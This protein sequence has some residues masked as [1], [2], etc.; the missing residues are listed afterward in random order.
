MRYFWAIFLLVSITLVSILGFRG[1][2][3]TQPPFYI[4]PDMDFQAKYLPQGKNPFFKD[5]RN[6]R[7]S[8][9]G[10]IARG[11]A[12]T[13]ELVFSND[14]SYLPAQNSELY[15]GKTP[16][17]EWFQGFPVPITYTLIQQG[18][19]K[20]EIFCKV[21]HGST[22]DGNGITKQY[23]ISATPSYHDDRIRS[24]HEG[25]IFNT[26]THGKNTMFPYG[27]KLSPQE[28]WAVVAYVRCLQ[29]AQMGT[30]DDV[31]EPSKTA[32]GL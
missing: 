25:E 23:G 16:A 7:Q 6:D 10:V 19:E 30:I 5:S 2:K 13:K 29:R 31:P 4:F 32:L 21:C 11:D 8:P 17:G 28:R 20:F 15:T 9:P 14:Y 27:D 12:Q 3:S 18:R 1:R 24:M 26:I 22:G